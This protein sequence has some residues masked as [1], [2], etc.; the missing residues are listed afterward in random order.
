M[1]KSFHL[2]YLFFLI[3]FLESSALLSQDKLITT[4]LSVDFIRHPDRVLKNGYPVS[5]ELEEALLENDKYQIIDICKKNPLL[6]W[7]IL[8]KKENTFQIAYRIIVS[9]NKERIDSDI[10]DIWDS[11]KIKSDHSI[12]VKYSGKKL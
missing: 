7:Q 8:S 1:K 11:K 4:N 2:K 6:S 3:I 12:N 5:V 10:G 9:S